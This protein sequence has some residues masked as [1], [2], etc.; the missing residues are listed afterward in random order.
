MALNALSQRLPP[1]AI[2][3]IPAHGLRDA[4]VE[5]LSVFGN[6]VTREAEAAQLL[7]AAQARWIDLNTKLDELERLIGPAR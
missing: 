1:I 6:Q 5:R 3:E 4:G 2:G 7:S